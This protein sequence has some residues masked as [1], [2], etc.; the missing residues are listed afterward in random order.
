[1]HQHSSYLH[2]QQSNDDDEDIDEIA[3]NQERGQN[4]IINRTAFGNSHHLTAR[5]TSKRSVFDQSTSN[6]T[7]NLSPEDLNPSNKTSL[8]DKTFSILMKL[9]Q[10]SIFGAVHYD[11]VYNE[12]D[13]EM[14]MKQ[15]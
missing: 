9:V 14:K 11:N 15:I 3:L 10:G 6:T 12:L 7:S 4:E 1:M 2:Y 13:N 5:M 8:R